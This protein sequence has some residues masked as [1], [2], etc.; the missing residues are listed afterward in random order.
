MVINKGYLMQ[1]CSRREAMILLL[2]GV[3]C[4]VGCQTSTGFKKPT[5][6]ENCY[7]VEFPYAWICFP[8]EG[9]G[10]GKETKPE[11]PSSLSRPTLYR[12]FSVQYS[13]K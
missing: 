13:D 8:L 5:L 3:A 11:V 10:S 7:W 12:K 1:K 4:L 9:P 2:G 6:P